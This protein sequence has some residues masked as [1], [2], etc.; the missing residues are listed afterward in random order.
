MEHV[1]QLVPHPRD[2]NGTWDVFVRDRKTGTTERVSV[3]PSGAQGNGI[4]FVHSIPHQLSANGRFVAFYS[5]ATNLVPG[6]TNGAGDVFV[7]DLKTGRTERVDVGPGGVQSNG[8]SAFSAGA[9]LSADGRIVAFDSDSSN[10]VPHDTNG[11]YDVFV[12]RR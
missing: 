5:E 7:R 1:R 12:R 8:P 11:L 3:A 9:S 2:T 10:L 4:S 6:D